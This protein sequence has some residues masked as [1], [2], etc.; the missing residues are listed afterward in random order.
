MP[1]HGALTDP[2]GP[3]RSSL[4]AMGLS[5]LCGGAFPLMAQGCGSGMVLRTAGGMGLAGKYMPGL[6]ALSGLIEGPAQSR[7][8]SFYTSSFG[9]GSAAFRHPS[10]P[11]NV[12]QSLS[13]R[14]PRA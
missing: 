7:A 3:R 5:G 8:V 9:I 10:L 11:A 4:L 2:V 6:K 12:F 14:G 1:G 13:D